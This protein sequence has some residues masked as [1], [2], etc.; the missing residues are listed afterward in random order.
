MELIISNVYNVS[1]VKDR[2]GQLVVMKFQL[3]KVFKRNSL[4]LSR[5]SSQQ[6]IS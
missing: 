3:P 2:T 4:N 6:F 5:G 1:R